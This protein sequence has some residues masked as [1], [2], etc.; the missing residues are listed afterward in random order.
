MTAPKWGLKS[1]GRMVVPPLYRTKHAP[2]GIFCAVESCPGIWGVIA[3]DGKVEIE[4]RYEGVVIRPDGTVKLTVFNG[5]T[6][7]NKL[8]D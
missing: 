1:N 6:V 2:V 7:I 8:K 4:P 3:I 5:K